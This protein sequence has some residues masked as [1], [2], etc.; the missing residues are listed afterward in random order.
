[1]LVRYKLTGKLSAAVLRA[2]SLKQKFK[3]ASVVGYAVDSLDMVTAEVILLQHQ[4]DLGNS[5]QRVA[6]EEAR[7]GS[8][9]IGS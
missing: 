4:L 7:N 1:M 5:G 8:L 6:S 2:F 3:V 9:G